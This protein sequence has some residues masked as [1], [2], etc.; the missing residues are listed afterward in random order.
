M[1]QENVSGKEYSLEEKTH[2]KEKKLTMS[3]SEIKESISS[4][5][6]S[7]KAEIKGEIKPEVKEYKITY[8]KS[9]IN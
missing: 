1:V 5:L 9:K 8:H 4:S 2:R 3:V 7:K 6:E